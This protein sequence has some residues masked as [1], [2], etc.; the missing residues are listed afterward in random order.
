MREKL[1]GRCNMRAFGDSRTTTGTS[2]QPPFSTHRGQ[3]TAGPNAL[4]QGGPAL[5][6]GKP[7]FQ[8]SHPLGR[9]T[10]QDPLY[11]HMLARSNWEMVAQGSRVSRGTPGRA[12]EARWDEGPVIH[13]CPACAER[14]SA[15]GPANCHARMIQMRKPTRTEGGLPLGG[16]TQGNGAADGVRE[17]RATPACKASFLGSV[18]PRAGTPTLDTCPE[19]QREQEEGPCPQGACT[20]PGRQK[21]A[22]HK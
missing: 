13:N 22:E 20:E 17:L 11:S 15:R 5:G 10:Y 6:S 12:Q 18:T 14:Y 19:K 1:Q 8:H 16:L 7:P 2:P 3:G 9:V 21:R 4:T